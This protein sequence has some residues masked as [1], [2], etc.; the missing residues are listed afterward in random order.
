VIQAGQA[1]PPSASRSPRDSIVIGDVPHDWL[2]PKM[3]AL[4]HHAGGDT[5]VAGC[6]PGSRP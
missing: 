5:T 1:G 6:A 2:F 3:A 4:V